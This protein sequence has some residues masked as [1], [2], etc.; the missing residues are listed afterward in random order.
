M[1]F[2]DFWDFAEDYAAMA[3]VEGAAK[4]VEITETTEEGFSFFGGSTAG[5]TRK[6]RTAKVRTI[7]EFVPNPNFPEKVIGAGEDGFCPAEWIE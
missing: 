5:R 6:V 2:A 4:V 1:R 7:R 3:V